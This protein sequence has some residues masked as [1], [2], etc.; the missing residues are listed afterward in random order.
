[1]RPKKSW[2]DGD[3][4]KRPKKLIHT[5]RHPTGKIIKVMGDPNKLYQCRV[6]KDYKHAEHF[7]VQS[8]DHWLRMRLKKTC[9]KCAGKGAFSLNFFR[10]VLD[11]PISCSCCGDYTSELIIDHD[12]ETGVFRGHTCY[13]CNTGMGNLGDTKEG[14]VRGAMYMFEFD[15]DKLIHYIISKYGSNEFSR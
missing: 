7:A 4:I 9:I 11:K 8:P 5:R 10:K 15:S 13:P 1:M 14:V 6:C 12:H 2:Y 3:D